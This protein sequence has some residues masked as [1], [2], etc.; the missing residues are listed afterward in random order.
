MIV[1]LSRLMLH[2][3]YESVVMSSERIANIWVLLFE[4]DGNRFL[5]IHRW[6]SIICTHKTIPIY[7]TYHN[8]HQQKLQKWT[9]AMNVNYDWNSTVEDLWDSEP[10]T[11]NTLTERSFLDSHRLSTQLKAEEELLQL[12]DSRWLC[13]WPQHNLA[14]SLLQSLTRSHISSLPAAAINEVAKVL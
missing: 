1:L 4:A 2:Q 12:F 13:F 3:K 5:L 8:T 10:Q 9:S 7:S 6:L 14:Q 11:K